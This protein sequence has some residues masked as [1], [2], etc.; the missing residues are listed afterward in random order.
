MAQLSKAL[1]DPTPRT[2][3]AVCIILKTIHLTSPR[4]R[5]PTAM[6]RLQAHLPRINQARAQ[7]MQH[8]HQDLV[9]L[10]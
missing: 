8:H 6:C 9:T 3:L 10:R 4:P 7:A 2:P 5:H 1:V